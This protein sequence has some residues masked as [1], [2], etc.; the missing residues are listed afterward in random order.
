MTPSQTSIGMTRR[1]LEI[2]VLSVPPGIAGRAEIAAAGAVD[3]PAAA[4]AV[5]DVVV[6]AAV[7]A[8]VDAAAMEDM[9]VPGTRNRING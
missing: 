9:A 2:V 3:V 1:L 4:E 5:V 7:A 6:V 8:V